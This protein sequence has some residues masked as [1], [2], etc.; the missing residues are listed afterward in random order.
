MIFIFTSYQLTALAVSEDFFEKISP[1]QH[2]LPT[3]VPSD[4]RFEYT[5]KSKNRM[6]QPYKAVLKKGA[7]IKSLKT[8]KVERTVRGV[9]VEARDLK[10]G[11]PFA[12]IYDKFDTPIYL[13]ETKNLK[14]TRDLTRLT[15]KYYPKTQ[16]QDFKFNSTDMKKRIKLNLLTYGAT[17]SLKDFSSTQANSFGLTSEFSLEIKDILPIYIHADINRLTSESVSWMLFN[18]GLKVGKKFNKNELRIGIETTI[19]GTASYSLSN[20]S[21]R[22]NKL[23]IGYQ[24]PRGNFLFEFETGLTKLIYSSET[25]FQETGITGSDNYNPYI[26]FKVGMNFDLGLL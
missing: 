7:L 6:L 10:L 25:N 23:L 11:S 24:I 22:S 17:H 19:I 16:K 3:A 12:V 26:A 4:Y 15:P 5:D 2:K 21:L 8:K 20:Q 14:K 18:A 1:P 9:L 13:C